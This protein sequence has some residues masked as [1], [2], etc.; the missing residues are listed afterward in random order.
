[1]S[2]S[3]LLELRERIDRESGELPTVDLAT[4]RL[5]PPVGQ[6]GKVVCVGLNY[7]GHAAEA[8]QAPPE[9]P[10]LFLKAADTVAGPYD[11]ILL[12][13]GSQKTDYEVELA[14]V[15][16]VT[17]RYLTEGDD[18]LSYI[19]GYAVSNDVSE[20]E[21]QLEHGGQWDKGKNCEAFYP[22]GPWLATADEVPDSQALHLELRV[23]GEVRQSASTSQMIFGVGSLVRYISRFMV[24][25]PGDVVSTGTP[26]GVGLGFDPP[27][28][29]AEGD[30]VELSV[31]GLGRQRSTCR[32]A[33]VASEGG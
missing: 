32:R 14:A 7:K 18:P 9:E 16:G 33:K 12:P 11:D 15:V 20:R 10:V 28:Y 26:E 17:A 8:R 4:V 1:L 23:N 21:Y 5:G 6:V 22:L 27:R 31:S 30:V 13:P 24:L 19:A 29:L 25:Y 2:A 3:K